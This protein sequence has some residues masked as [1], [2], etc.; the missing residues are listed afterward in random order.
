MFDVTGTIGKKP[1]EISLGKILADRNDPK[2]I[3]KITKM[4]HRTKHV[5]NQL[6]FIPDEAIRESMINLYRQHTEKYLEKLTGIPVRGVPVTDVLVS[7]TMCCI[8]A[9]FSKKE[10]ENAN[11]ED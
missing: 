4:I 9:Y 10:D 2:L 7:H 11:D 1:C 8:H 5:L 3:S 6:E